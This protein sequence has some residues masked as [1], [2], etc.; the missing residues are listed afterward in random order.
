MSALKTFSGNPWAGRM[1]SRPLKMSQ[2]PMGSVPYRVPITMPIPDTFGA[3]PTPAWPSADPLGMPRTMGGPRGA[4]AAGDPSWLS[5]FLKKPLVNLAALGSTVGH[6]LTGNVGALMADV[7][8][9]G[10]A[11]GIRE[12]T[13]AAPPPPRAQGLPSGVG[14]VPNAMTSGMNLAP[15]TQNPLFQMSQSLG[16]GAAAMGSSLSSYFG[17]QPD[18]GGEMV[19]SGGGAGMLYSH[20][21]GHSKSKA[22]PVASTKGIRP[23]GYHINKSGYYLSSISTWLPPGTVWVKGRRRNP[24]NPRALHR[25]IARLVSA[26]HAVKKLG[27]LEVP[28]PRRKARAF[29]VPK[30]RSV[31]MLKA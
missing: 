23:S 14:L 3:Q 12:I 27:M 1:V 25:S 2:L 19:P 11:F 17:Q 21:F 13:G 26:K 18:Q 24:L 15:M 29:L 8:T 4:F 9:M 16:Q 7:G 30:G 20:F 22:I 10:A 5:T 6:A 28:R 31:K